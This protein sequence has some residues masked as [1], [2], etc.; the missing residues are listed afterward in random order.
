MRSR[1]QLA[2]RP[3]RVSPQHA[4]SEPPIPGAGCVARSRAR[5]FMSTLSAALRPICR[6]YS[7]VPRACRLGAPQYARSGPS[8]ARS[9]SASVSARPCSDATR[10]VDDHPA[11]PVRGPAGSLRARAYGF[12]PRPPGL[13]ASP[14]RHGRPRGLSRTGRRCP[15]PPR[16]GRRQ[17]RFARRALAPST[18]SCP[19]HRRATGRCERLTVSRPSLRI[20][21]G[22]PGGAR[23]RSAASPTAV[24]SRVATSP[25][26]LL[27]TWALEHLL[28]LQRPPEGSAQVPTHAKIDLACSGVALLSISTHHHGQSTSLQCSTSPVTVWEL[29]ARAS[30]SA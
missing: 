14:A 17:I 26:W 24:S 21:R 20:R 5:R 1:A 12:R 13:A 4:V 8:Q 29:C 19:R 3:A 28:K 23:G 6:A 7:R 10:R 30:T 18:A 9:P 15:A 27:P 2:P 25:R 22:F 11:F 16:R